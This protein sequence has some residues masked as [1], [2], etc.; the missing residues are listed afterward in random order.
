MGR[1]NC[2]PGDPRL[3]T[4]KSLTDKEKHPSSTE[5][6]HIGALKLKTALL[7]SCLD[8]PRQ[9]RTLWKLLNDL[10]NLGWFR[11]SEKTRMGF[12]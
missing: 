3:E 5:P 12:L 10:V 11:L 8:G 2:F 9:G 1:R 4:E 6:I 7:G